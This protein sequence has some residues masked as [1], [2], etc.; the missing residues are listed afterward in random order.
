MT[1]GQVRDQ[2][3]KLLNQ[4]SV[5]GTLVPSSY[6]NQQDYLNRIPE[7]VND[8]MVEIATTAR[9]IPALVRLADLEQED[10]DNEVWYEL[11]EDFYQLVSGSIVTTREGRT[12]HTNVYSLQGKSY[13]LIPKKEV[14]N[15]SLVYYRYPTQ[16]SGQPS[17]GE[18]L[19]NEPE[20]HFAIPFYVASFLVAQDDSFLCSLFYNKY[21]DKLAKMGLGVT[22]E[23]RSVE[24][25]YGFFC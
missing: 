13:L 10:R 9:K 5:A 1:Y 23:I 22:A 19:D 14:G 18:L 6:N 11:P 2:V 7:L 24:D 21:E 8:A 17:E 12:I 20:T 15:H 3:L 25:V 16:L 4:Y